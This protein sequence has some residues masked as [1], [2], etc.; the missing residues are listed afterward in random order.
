M[1]RVCIVGYGAIGPIHARALQNINGVELYGICDTNAIRLQQGVDAY[2][3]KPFSC[4]EDVLADPLVDCVHICTPHY[5]H[6]EMIC[7]ALSVGKGVISEKPVTM[8]KQQYLALL[9]Q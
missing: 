3:V 4:Y 9:H 6:Y 5:L 2:Q 7:K 8:T 1:K